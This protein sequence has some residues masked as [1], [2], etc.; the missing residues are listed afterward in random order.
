VFVAQQ[1]A[2]IAGAN[3]KTVRLV[4]GFHGIKGHEAP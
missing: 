2:E 3:G 1:I 4:H